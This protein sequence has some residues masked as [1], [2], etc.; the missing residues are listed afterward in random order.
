MKFQTIQTVSLHVDLNFI[1]IVKFFPRE[2]IPDKYG[3]CPK[4]GQLRYNPW[5]TFE[6]VL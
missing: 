4:I 3:T 5:T 1:P 2:K 6:T